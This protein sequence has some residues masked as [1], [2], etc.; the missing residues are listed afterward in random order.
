[1]IAF[2]FLFGVESP[3][4]QAAILGALTVTIAMLLFVTADLQH[5]FQGDLAVKP[6]GLE[7]GLQ[8]AR[9]AASPTATPAA[10]PT[11]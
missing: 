9:L 11:P 2:A 6:E 1:M 3:W 10:T 5:P 4:V 8:Q 7:L